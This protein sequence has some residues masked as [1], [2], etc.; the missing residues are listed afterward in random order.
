MIQLL[1]I[2]ADIFSFLYFVSLQIKYN[3]ELTS[4]NIGN[5]EIKYFS[6]VKLQN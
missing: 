5:V 1:I 6:F 3:K 2:N 4:V